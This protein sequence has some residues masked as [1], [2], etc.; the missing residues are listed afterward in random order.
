[1]GGRSGIFGGAFNPVHNGHLGIAHSFLNSG[2]INELLILPVWH[3]PHKGNSSLEN[4]DHRIEMARIAFSGVDGC[5]VSD[6]ESRLDSPSY[7]LKTVDYL[8][9]RNPQTTWFLCMGEDSAASLKK[10][11]QYRELLEKVTVLIAS[12]PGYSQI[13]VEPDLRERMI[14]VEHSPDNLSSSQIRSGHQQ[15]EVPDGVREY[16]IKHKLYPE[17]FRPGSI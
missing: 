4:F 5:K 13:S 2:L 16:I 15:E 12:R 3:P 9:H 11:Y 14:W 6:L 10:W 8:N 1:M 7:T 17:T